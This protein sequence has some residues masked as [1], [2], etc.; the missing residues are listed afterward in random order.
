MEFAIFFLI[1]MIIVL[2]YNTTN[3]E[4]IVR[5]KFY[6]NPRFDMKTISITIVITN[7]SSKNEYYNIKDIFYVYKSLS[8][9]DIIKYIMNHQNLYYDEL[10]QIRTCFKKEYNK[11]PIIDNILVEIE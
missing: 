11:E 9:K 5:K 4:P 10:M 8:N 7:G 2:I 6:G 3:T 1:F